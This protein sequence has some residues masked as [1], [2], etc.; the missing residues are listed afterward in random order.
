M[1]QIISTGI[2]YMRVEHEESIVIS[3]CV[4]LS[5]FHQSSRTGSGSKART[6][7]QPYHLYI[8]GG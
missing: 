8:L 1:D 2:L 5:A 6:P 4:A 3:G 7:Q